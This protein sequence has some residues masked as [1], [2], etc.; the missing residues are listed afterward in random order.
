MTN[1]NKFRIADSMETGSIDNHVALSEEFSRDQFCSK[2]DPSEVKYRVYH[3][4]NFFNGPIPTVHY[5]G[6]TSGQDASD[7]LAAM[8]KSPRKWDVDEIIGEK[9]S[10]NEATELAMTF[11]KENQLL[12]Y[13]PLEIDSMFKCLAYKPS[14][15]W[16]LRIG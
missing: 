1:E 10:L 12:L 11:A 7:Y 9:L 14:E 2:P 4:M 5:T 13:V 15:D 16:K 8:C 3:R 6:C